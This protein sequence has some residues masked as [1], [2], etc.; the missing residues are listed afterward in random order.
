MKAQKKVLWKAV[1]MVDLMA[2]QM[3]ASSDAPGVDTKAY[4]KVDPMV[5]TL[6]LMSEVR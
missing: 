4:W 5:A 6:G 2:S 3:A 1:R